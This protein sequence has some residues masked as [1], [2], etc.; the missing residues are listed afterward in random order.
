MEH[1]E[2]FHHRPVPGAG[3]GPP[4][5]GL[6]GKIG[7]RGRVLVLAAL[8]AV[9]FAVFRGVT[10]LL[11]A[12]ELE[13]V[14]LHVPSVAAEPGQTALIS[15]T[16]RNRGAVPGAAFLVAV[17]EGGLEIEGP[18]RQVASGETAVVSVEVI[19]NSGQAPFSVAVF[20]GWRGAR[21]VRTYRSVEA[22]VE[23]RRIRLEGGTFPERLARGERARLDMTWANPGATAETVV[24]VGVFR[25]REGGPP[26]PIEG[27]PV[28]IGPGASATLALPVDSWLLHEGAWELAV[29]VRSGAGRRAGYGERAVALDVT[30]P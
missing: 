9:A 26:L 17:L 18:T 12:P 16:V 4:D 14:E 6:G 20:D 25:S 10:H 5:Q 19:V 1:T 24:P 30:G 29:E 8:L 7:I 11:F 28:R 3:T 2:D 22:P 27:P 13:V 23:P 21:A 15:V